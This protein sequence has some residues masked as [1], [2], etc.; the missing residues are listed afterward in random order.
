MEREDAWYL[1]ENWG[2]AISVVPLEMAAKAAKAR[3]MH[4]CGRFEDGTTIA[5]KAAE[6]KELRNRNDF[7]YRLN[8]WKDWYDNAH[9]RVLA[10]NAK[11]LAEKGITVM[12]TLQAIAGNKPVE[13]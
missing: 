3:V 10:E 7:P 13:L 11:S 4:Y 8:L 12:G 2:Q 9:C 5:A 1:Q 6:L